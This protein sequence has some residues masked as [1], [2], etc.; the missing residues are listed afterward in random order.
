MGYYHE[1]RFRSLLPLA[2]HH[3]WGFEFYRGHR[4]HHFL[5][6]Y[7]VDRFME[8][9]LPLNSETEPAVAVYK[10]GDPASVPLP[11]NQLCLFALPH[12]PQVNTSSQRR[13]N[14]QDHVFPASLDCRQP[15]EDNVFYYHVRGQR[16]RVDVECMGRT[17]HMCFE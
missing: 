7:D 8:M 10:H 16:A 9:R 2:G 6:N 14:S 15:P 1:H 17:E 11:G 13:D 4:Y 5:H 12:T 3:I